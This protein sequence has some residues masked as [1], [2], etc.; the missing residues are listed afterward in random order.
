MWKQRSLS[1]SF[2][3]EE[4]KNYVSW[5]ANKGYACLRMDKRQSKIQKICV[6]VL[7]PPDI[8]PSV[9]SQPLL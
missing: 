4:N 6:L 1:L 5:D 3:R 7:I 8:R 9:K 2:S